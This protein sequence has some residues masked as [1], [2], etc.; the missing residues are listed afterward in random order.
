MSQTARRRPIATMAILWIVLY[1]GAVLLPVVLANTLSW[2]HRPESGFLL[3]LSRNLALAGLSILALQ[4]VVAARLQWIE[5]Y[6]GL[7]AIL[8]FH[9]A[10]AVFAVLMLLA[11]PLLIAWGHGNWT[12]LSRL[13]VPWPVQLGRIALL[14]L[15]AVVGTSLGRR[16]FRLEYERWRRLH[17]VLVLAVLGLGFVHGLIMG[18]GRHGD[19]S[20][21]PMRILWSGLFLIALAAYLHHRWFAPRRNRLAPCEVIAV[22][23]ESHDVWTIKVRATLNGNGRRHLPGQFYFITFLDSALPE[24]EHP[25]SIS[26][27]PTENGY[28]TFTIKAAGDFTQSIASLRPGDRAMIRG[29]FGRFSHILRSGREDIVFI[30]GGVG[31]TPLISMLRYMRDTGDPRRVVLIFVNRAQRDILFRDE[32]EKMQRVGRPQLRVIHVL[33]RPQGAWNG[34][35]GRLN[36]EIMQKYISDLVGTSSFYICG[37]LPLTRLAIKI[38]RQMGVFQADIHTEQFTF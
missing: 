7:D 12:I 32:L 8:W 24:E 18:S 15:L 23:R 14:L 4:F 28:L 25:F 34:E 2:A 9:K 11:H 16:V 36:H 38:L 1:T 10:M 6:F 22:G 17:N 19:L 13:V 27:S 31:I 29:P 21:W 20:T 35:T 5:A 37:P 30:A 26:S 3:N 33:S